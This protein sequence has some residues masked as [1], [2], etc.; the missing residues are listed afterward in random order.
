MEVSFKTFDKI[1]NKYP[2]N[3]NQIIHQYYTTL[4]EDCGVDQQL[5][6]FCRYYRCYC[7][8]EIQ[9]CNENKYSKFL[10]CTP[11]IEICCCSDRVLCP[12]CWRVDLY[13]AINN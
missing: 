13:R 6:S 7:S 10:C 9:I 3:I 2:K 1:M 11:G 12:R 4:C 8:K 5:C